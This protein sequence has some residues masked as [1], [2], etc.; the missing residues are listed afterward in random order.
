VGGVVVLAVA[1]VAVFALTLGHA[2]DARRH[3]VDAFPAETTRPAKAAGAAASAVNILLLGTDVDAADPESPQFVGKREADTVMLL[4]VPAD[5]SKVYAVSV[6][7]NS[8]VQVPGHGQQAINAAYAFGGTR[9]TVQTV[10]QLL[11]VRIDHVVDVSLDGLKGLTD[12]LGGVEVHTPVAF[13]NDGV[14]FRAGRQ[15]LDGRQALA[16]LRAGDFKATGDTARAAA[17]EQY[18]RGVLHQVLSARLLLDPAALAASVNVFAPYLSTDRDFDA[19]AVTA[20]GVS[21]RDVRSDDLVTVR[22]AGAGIDQVAGATVVRLDPAR[23]RALSEALRTD[24]MRSY[25]S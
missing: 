17:Q 9:L 8:L 22:V 3:V 25:A 15:T 23:V 19:A 20:L 2:Y 4:H 14:E 18:F 6:L 10:E 13:A 1:A 16:Y 12:A 11:D 21:L 7:R 5:R 24:A